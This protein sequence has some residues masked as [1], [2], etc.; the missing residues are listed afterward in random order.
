MSR[1]VPVHVLQKNGELT[2]WVFN[3]DVPVAVLTG[4]SCGPIPH[5]SEPL[6]NKPIRFSIQ[7]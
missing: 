3:R 6:S 4:H 2:V 5:L 1:N 7:W